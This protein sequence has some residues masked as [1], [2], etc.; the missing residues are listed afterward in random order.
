MQNY[1]IIILHRHWRETLD[2]VIYYGAGISL[3]LGI[4]GLCIF[5]AF[6]AS[7]SATAQRRLNR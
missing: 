7:G 5:R 3:I 2:C 4:L 6:L 1:H